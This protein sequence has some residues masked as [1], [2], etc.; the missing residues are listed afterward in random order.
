MTKA[1]HDE[2]MIRQECEAVRTELATLKIKHQELVR[3]KAALESKYSTLRGT[4]EDLNR[5]DFCVKRVEQTLEQRKQHTIDTLAEENTMLQ[6]QIAECD[7]QI[8]A[9]ACT[10]E[11]SAAELAAMEKRAIEGEQKLRCSS[12]EMAVLVQRLAQEQSARADLQTKVELWARETSKEAA[13]VEEKNAMAAQLEDITQQLLATKRTLASAVQDNEALTTRATDLDAALSLAKVREDETLVQ[14]QEAQDR[15]SAALLAKEREISQLAQSLKQQQHAFDAASQH[16][17]S[18]HDADM[19]IILAQLDDEA[20]ERSRLSKLNA[21]HVEALT[22]ELRTQSTAMSDR[23]REWEQ[24]M[25][26]K[27][28]AHRA[29]I[30][31]KECALSEMRETNA[32]LQ[33]QIDKLQCRASEV[34]LAL[35]SAQQ[36]VRLNICRSMCCSHR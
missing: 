28:E 23:A 36:T 22:S 30:A 16:A 13:L 27:E 1:V 10:L 6:S 12:E 5:R 8:A 15:H 19:A 25:H 21:Q 35:A 17:Q 24:T 9:L 20:S 31:S 11:A 18:R 2:Q 7:S 33:Q 3:Q 4:N 14:L 32:G 29:L 34:A 26:G